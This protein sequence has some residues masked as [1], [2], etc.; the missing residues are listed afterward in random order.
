LIA[1]I[2]IEMARSPKGHNS[3]GGIVSEIQSLKSAIDALG[4][5]ISL[6]NNLM[7]WGFSVAAF[8]TV[9]G[10]A[11]TKI[12]LLKT[13][14]QSRKQGL[15]NAAEDRQLQADLRSKDLQISELNADNLDMRYVMDST[16]HL[17]PDLGKPLPF[18]K[19][20]DTAKMYVG[21]MSVADAE[22]FD[23]AQEIED[24]LKRSV[25]NSDPTLFLH[26]SRLNPGIEVWSSDPNLLGLLP[27]VKAIV[28]HSSSIADAIF[29][30]LQS[31][32][33]HSVQRKIDI[34]RLSGH[35]EDLVNRGMEVRADGVLIL[36]GNKNLADELEY[37]KTLRPKKPKIQTTQ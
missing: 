14:E 34:D 7:I 6:W 1:S 35:P 26:T 5:S 33:I 18:L 36:V 29:H 30:W 28:A 22:S 17:K 25:W 27:D 11:A 13:E 15:L 4:K 21:I 31:E 19:P 20:S 16:R 12:A 9:C 10:V 8:F 24:K 23:L 3:D 37:R 32:G 2:T